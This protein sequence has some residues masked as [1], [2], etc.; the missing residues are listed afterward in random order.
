ML[1]LMGYYKVETNVSIILGRLI[2]HR[3][4]YLQG[5]QRV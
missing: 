2:K 4:T 3:G 1:H 5:V